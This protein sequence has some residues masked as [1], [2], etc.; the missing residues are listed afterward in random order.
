MPMV[1]VNANVDFEREQIASV[2]CTSNRCLRWWPLL[3]VP[4][5]IGCIGM[6]FRKSLA[7]KCEFGISS[8]D[9]QHRQMSPSILALNSGFGL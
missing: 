8:K 4:A 1:A 6:I 3:A 7:F 5:N 9:V 2:D